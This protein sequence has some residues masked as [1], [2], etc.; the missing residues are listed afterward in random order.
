MKYLTSVYEK[1]AVTNYVTN[2]CYKFVTQFVTFEIAILERAHE[3]YITQAGTHDTERL[4]EHAKPPLEHSFPPLR[5]PIPP[6]GP[7]SD[8]N[9]RA[10]E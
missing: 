10:Q 7:K 6:T 3:L 1:S 5:A 9:L 8:Q 4:P 2:F